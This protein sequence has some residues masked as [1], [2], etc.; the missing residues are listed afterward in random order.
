MIARP[1]PARPAPTPAPVI[2]W[3]SE[4][5]LSPEA[6]RAAARLLLAVAH[7]RRER[8]QAGGDHHHQEPAA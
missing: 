6:I 4:P 8:E 5:S 1:L 2:S 3:T 7:Q